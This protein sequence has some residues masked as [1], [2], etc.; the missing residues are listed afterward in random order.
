M[1]QL[2]GK[3][4]TVL[5]VHYRGRTSG[6]LRIDASALQ[7]SETASIPPYT[8]DARASPIRNFASLGLNEREK[9]INLLRNI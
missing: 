3:M 5:L 9:T 8:S 2:L 4:S 6:K 1:K 7:R